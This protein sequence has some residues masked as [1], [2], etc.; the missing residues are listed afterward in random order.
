MSLVTGGMSYAVDQ[1]VGN[2]SSGNSNSNTIQDEMTAAL[3]AQLGQTTL[4]LL[5]K[6]LNIKPTLEIRAGF[7]IN[8]VV[9]VWPLR[10]LMA[11]DGYRNIW[12]GT[13]KTV[14]SFLAISLLTSRRPFS[15]SDTRFCLVPKSSASFS[16]VRSNL[17]LNPS[18]NMP[19]ALSGKTSA[20]LNT[21][22]PSSLRSLT[23]C[24]AVFKAA[25]TASRIFKASLMGRLR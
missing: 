24:P 11:A 6:R 5:Q 2:D 19:G 10:G 7:M 16:W 4:Q 23:R 12:Y 14:P 8:V 22:L 25:D 13:L 15:K 20:T 9:T 1:V 17:S 3:A 18:I 21:S